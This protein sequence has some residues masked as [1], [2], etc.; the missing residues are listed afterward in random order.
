MVYIIASDND[1]LQICN[2]KILMIK[3]N[4]Q[5]IE[6]VTLFGEKY[7]IKKIL[8]FNSKKI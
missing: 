7:L 4:L 1:Y 2:S 6:P 5:P 8:F 3:G